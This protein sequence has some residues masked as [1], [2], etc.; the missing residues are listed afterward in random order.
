MKKLR[1]L[2]AAVFLLFTF[3]NSNAQTK[4]LPA[5]DIM[6]E[7]LKEAD[8]SGKNIFVIFHASWCGWC[9]KMDNSMQD[10]SIAGFFKNNYIV[11]HL[12][13]DESKDKKD[14]ENPG[15]QAIRTQYHGNEQGLPYWFIL[16]KNG[17]LIA[18]S[19]LIDSS[20]KQGN[21]IGCP[22]Q[23]DEV[24][25]FIKVMRKSSPLKEADLQLIRARFLK[26]GQ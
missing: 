11:K 21:N 25:Y 2:I 23:P 22:S 14:L 16:D 3:T 5:A 6:K 24:D 12:T 4:P 9:H 17:K 20:G 8:Q 13:I 10:E 26:N 19:R 18:D 1:F 15:A 7:A